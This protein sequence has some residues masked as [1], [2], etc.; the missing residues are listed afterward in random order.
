M[1]QTENC[2]VS[3]LSMHRLARPTAQK[4][5]LRS[6]FC[7]PVT[8]CWL[9]PASALFC[10]QKVDF[11][12]AKM[13]QWAVAQVRVCRFSNRKTSM[14]YLHGKMGASAASTAAALSLERLRKLEA[15]V[16]EGEKKKSGQLFVLGHVED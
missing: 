5:P 7:R 9:H 16:G 11:Y 6:R 14:A 13:R 12:H 15:L 2:R 3:I 8:S 4:L 10:T 1:G